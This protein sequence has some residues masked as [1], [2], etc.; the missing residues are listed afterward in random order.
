MN[1][2]KTNLSK[3]INGIIAAT[4]LAFTICMLCWSLFELL[5]DW[6]KTGTINTDE[7]VRDIWVGLAICL[8]MSIW[9]SICFSEKVAIKTPKIVR[10]LVFA[11]IGYGI[12]TAWVFG[13]GWCPAEGF[14]LFSIICIAALA[15]AC[16]ITFIVT[17]IEDRRLDA[18]L[19]NYKSK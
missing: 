5:P 14:G 13:S 15:L 1:S 19:K 17:A 2:T 9:G 8:C 4:T 3:T 18:Q 7:A 11:V 16:I 6:S 12:I 10:F